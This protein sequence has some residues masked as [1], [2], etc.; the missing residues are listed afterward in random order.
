[1]VSNM[2]IKDG[3]PN[4]KPGPPRTKPRPEPRKK[5][6]PK[7]GPLPWKKPQATVPMYGLSDEEFLKMTV[8]HRKGRQHDPEP[9]YICGRHMKL[10]DKV[11][12]QELYDSMDEHFIIPFEHTHRIPLIKDIIKRQGFELIQ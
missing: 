2:T 4:K 5:G 10:G 11:S 3:L 12:V 7:R 8:F 9:K 1:M 6:Q